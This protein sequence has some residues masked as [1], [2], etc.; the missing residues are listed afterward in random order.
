MAEIIPNFHN[1]ASRLTKLKNVIEKNPQGR[2]ASCQSLVDFC[3]SQKTFISKVAELEATLPVQVTHNDT[4]INNLLF[5]SKTKEPIAVIDLDTCMPG[6]VMHDFGDMVRTCCST[7]PEDGT[8]LSDME[9]RLDILDALAK[10]YI[11]SFDGNMSALEQES[12]V[13]GAQ[14][15]PFMIGVRFLTDYIDGDNYFHTTHD[16][17]NLERAENQIHLFRSLHTIEEQL[18]NIILF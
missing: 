11:E 13:I 17:H 2:L 8:N 9:I 14:L 6:F 18:S 16:S 3:L 15:L 12:L 1:L 4:K 10:A 5:N 7:L